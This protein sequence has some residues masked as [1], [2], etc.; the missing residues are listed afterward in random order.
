[1]PI[2]ATS[3]WSAHI[4]MSVKDGLGTWKI[5]FFWI[6]GITGLAKDEHLSS[7]WH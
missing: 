3:G 6:T 4:Y 2:V 7:Y 1:V 5:M